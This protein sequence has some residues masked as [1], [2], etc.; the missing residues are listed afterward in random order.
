MSILFEVTQLLADA[1]GRVHHLPREIVEIGLF[2]SLRRR[3][4]FFKFRVVT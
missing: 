2:A 3:R 4:L 1:C